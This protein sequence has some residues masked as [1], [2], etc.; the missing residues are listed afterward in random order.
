MWIASVGAVWIASVHSVDRVSCAVWIG[1]DSVQ[2]GSVGAVWIGSVGAV[3]IGSVDSWCSV[4][5]VS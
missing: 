3:W 5:R 4:D 2:T 1:S